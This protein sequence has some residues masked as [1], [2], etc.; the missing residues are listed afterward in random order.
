MKK[1]KIIL[2]TTLG[3]CMLSFIPAVLGKAD[4][5]PI[6]DFTATN[7]N[8]LAYVDP[9]SGLLVVPHGLW[10]LPD[11]ETI[12]DCDYDGFVLERDL[13]DGRILYK[14]NLHVKGA[15]MLIFWGQEG[16]YLFPPIFVGEM[17]YYFTTT[18]IVEGEFGGPVPNLIDVWYNG[19][20]ETLM[21][22]ITGSGTGEFTDYAEELGVGISGDPVKAFVNQVGIPRPEGHPFYPE[23]WPV[24]LVFFH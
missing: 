8:I 22:H 10:W 18:I 11:P 3:I 4:C 16:W 20:G 7:S 2:I 5:R 23:M 13:K 9:E 21:S 19:G 1:T 12:A 14:I 6:E 24:E 17:D 15:L